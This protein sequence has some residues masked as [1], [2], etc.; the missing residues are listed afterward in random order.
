[1]KE[2]HRPPSAHPLPLG[3][4]TKLNHLELGAVEGRGDV[5]SRLSSG[6]SAASPHHRPHQTLDIKMSRE[7]GQSSAVFLFAAAASG[8]PPIYHFPVDLSSSFL[9]HVIDRLS[10]PSYT[11]NIS[12][13]LSQWNIGCY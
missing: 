2:A 12:A 1:M 8:V 4:R 7:T 6:L 13:F 3:T 11:Q 9:V 5:T 10:F